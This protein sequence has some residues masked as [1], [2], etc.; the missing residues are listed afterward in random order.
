MEIDV[1]PA[2]CLLSGGVRVSAGMKTSEELKLR[3]CLDVQRMK[4]LNG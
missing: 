2:A 4:L 3:I 1:S